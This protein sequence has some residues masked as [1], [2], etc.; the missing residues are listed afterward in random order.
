MKKWECT[1]TYEVEKP[2]TDSEYG[3]QYYFPTLVVLAETRGQAKAL[4]ADAMDVEFVCVRAKV[5]VGEDEPDLPYDDYPSIYARGNGE[6]V[7]Y[8]KWLIFDTA[9]DNE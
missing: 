1:T 8:D 7:E 9:G 3:C 2:F 6:Y 4:F 5:Y